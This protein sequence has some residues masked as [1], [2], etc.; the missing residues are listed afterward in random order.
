MRD[1]PQQ[2]T[3]PLSRVTAAISQ[4]IWVGSVVAP[5][6]ARPSP[7]LPPVGELIWIMSDTN[8]RSKHPVWWWLRKTVPG[9]IVVPKGQGDWYYLAR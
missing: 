6:H 9:A 4:P 8:L 5:Q 3:F 1:K 2:Q 7:E